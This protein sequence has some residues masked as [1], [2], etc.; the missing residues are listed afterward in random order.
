MNLDIDFGSVIKSGFD[1]VMYNFVHKALYTIEILVCQCIDWLQ[2]LFGIFA[3]TATVK[4]GDDDPY[5]MEV[6]F[7][8]TAIAGVF[9]GMAAIGV[10]FAFLFSLIAVIRK[11]FDVDDKMKSTYGQILRNLFRSI[12]IILCLH[13]SMTVVIMFTNALMTS[14]TKVFDDGEKNQLKPHID[15]TDEQFAA[16]ARIFNTVG[17][18][19]LNPSY[20]N[21]Y[22]L[23]TCYNEIRSD[24]R[25]L[26]DTGVFDFYYETTDS[27]GRVVN[28]WQSVLQDIAS[29]ANYNNE[30]PVDVYNEAIANS[31]SNCMTVMR[32]DPSFRALESY[33]RKYEFKDE[34]VDLGRMVFLIGTMGI[35]K[36]AAA[37]NEAFNKDPKFTDSLRL[38]YYYGIKDVY[39]LDQVNQDFDIAYDKTNYIVVFFSCFVL[40][41]NMGIII[42]SC[43]VR[44]FN[45]LFLYIIAP[46][47][48]GIMPL[49]DGQ[50]FKQ[51][52]TAFIIQAF[53]VFATVISMRVFLIFIPVIMSPQLQLSDNIYLDMLGK[54][55][56]IWAGVIAVQRANGLL[57]G[58]LADSAGQQSLFAG[59]VGSDVRGKMMGMA[60]GALGLGAGAAK[61]G[62]KGAWKLGK[63]TV[64]TGWHGLTGAS[65]DNGQRGFWGNLRNKGVLGG[66]YAGVKSA[67]GWGYDKAT[68]KS[69][70]APD[71]VNAGASKSFLDDNGGG[72]GQSAGSLI[73]SKPS[74]SSNSAQTPP[75]KRNGSG[76]PGGPGGPS[77]PGGPGGLVSNIAG[78]T[79]S[80]AGTAIKATGQATSDVLDAASGGNLGAPVRNLT[81]G[82]G[83]G[84]ENAGEAIK[85][86]QG[87]NQQ[88]QGTQTN[89]QQ[90]QGGAPQGRGRS[91]SLPNRSNVSGGSKSQQIRNVAKNATMGDALKAA[92]VGTQYAATGQVNQNDVQDLAQRAQ[93]IDQRSGGALSQLANGNN[94]GQNNANGTKPADNGAG[95]LVRDIAGA[96]LGAAGAAIKGTGEIAGG[97]V[98]AVSGGNLGAPVRN[99]T[100]G[101]GGGLENTGEAIKG[102]NGTEGNAQGT[103]Q[104]GNTALPKKQGS[105]GKPAGGT[106]QPQDG[107]KKPNIATGNNQNTKSQSSGESEG[108]GAGETLA[109]IGRGVATAVG[110]GF[111]GVGMVASTATDLAGDALEGSTALA[112]EL[113]DEATGTHIGSAVAGIGGAAGGLTKGIGGGVGGTSK[114]VGEGFKSLGKKSED[115]ESKSGDKKG[116]KNNTNKPA[117]SS[118][119]TKPASGAQQN[120]PKNQQNLSE[121]PKP[122]TNTQGEG[123]A[124]PNNEGGSI[125]RDIAAAGMEAVGTAV[126]ATGEVAGGVVGT[127]AGEEA[128]SAV[129]GV[130]DTIGG[131]INKGADSLRGN[132]DS[133][134]NASLPKNQSQMTESAGGGS[135]ST[136][137]TSSSAGTGSTSSTSSSAGTGSSTSTSSSAGTGSTTSTSSSGGY[138]GGSYGSDDSSDKKQDKN[139]PSKLETFG[140]MTDSTIS[141]VGYGGKAAV[142]GIGSTI[143]EFGDWLFDVHDDKGGG[144]TPQNEQSRYEQLQP[145][146]ETDDEEDDDDDMDYYQPPLS[147]PPPPKDK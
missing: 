105:T 104:Q 135:S 91:H 39:D 24:I 139:K 111:Q 3:G 79:L 40:I 113:I 130:T 132:T 107:T 18:Y 71:D 7:N 120:L 36:T 5:L 10:T 123:N 106:Q 58:I 75:P 90:S 78:A 146:K 6:F 35:G 14:V 54:L 145:K 41:I 60:T 52:I 103:N 108:G 67:I 127:V 80:A 125:V 92:K 84:L 122:A 61:L 138:S 20:K 77:A 102:K 118:Q 12:L 34:E 81:E 76:G 115:G 31:L 27:K 51:W 59:D 137:S 46:P 4:Y 32:T 22:N 143:E 21:R 89:N 131:G 98:D 70:S 65:E 121:Q 85:G 26:A 144:A 1:Y 25:Y 93:R 56:A 140:R 11:I 134:D 126:Q 87:S 42:V 95:S 74:N 43:I 110:Y 29:A 101:V 44:I 129:T 109:A 116:T 30:A 128:G 99:L 16:M 66:M 69:D 13:F 83:G 136:T 37:R 53:S 48:I 23:N 86:N 100:E 38:P 119:G 15:F 33:D 49:D 133:G 17:N 124:K 96:T 55:I 28:T 57:T 73:G 63:G 141:S 88:G 147:E 64:K 45:L 82:V 68:S 142:E 62:L 97:A 112:G 47:I 94:A 117:G 19:S 2:Q 9:R 114:L 72:K 50:K 8:N